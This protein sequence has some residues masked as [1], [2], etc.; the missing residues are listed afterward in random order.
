[1]ISLILL[2]CIFSYTVLA[3]PEIELNALHTKQS[4]HVPCCYIKSNKYEGTTFFLLF[5]NIACLQTVHSSPKKYTL[6][7]TNLPCNPGI[8]PLV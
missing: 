4:K 3:N 2:Q 8:F 7:L 1:M 6:I 5:G